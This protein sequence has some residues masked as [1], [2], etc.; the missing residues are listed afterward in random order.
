MTITLSRKT[1]EILHIDEEPGERERLSGK[2]QENAE[3]MA[4]EIVTQLI[5][6]GQQT[7]A[8]N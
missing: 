6:E 5:Y 4:R 8:K 1:G 3:D 7:A 2:L